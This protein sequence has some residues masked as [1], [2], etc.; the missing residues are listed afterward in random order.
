[1]VVHE[2]GMER[3]TCWFSQCALEMDVCANDAWTSKLVWTCYD[4]VVQMSVWQGSHSMYKIAKVL[5]IC[6][7]QE[8][9]LSH[10]C[11]MLN[12]YMSRLVETSQCSMW[13]VS[14]FL[15]VKSGQ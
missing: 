11:P 5:G 6:G 4:T 12:A 9:F 8:G 15:C 2:L 1:M 14:N 10:L 13:C 3:T 7:S